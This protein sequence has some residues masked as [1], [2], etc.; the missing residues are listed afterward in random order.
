MNSSWS[1]YT[2][3]SG[4]NIESTPARYSQYGILMNTSNVSVTP[5]I[6]QVIVGYTI[7]NKTLNNNVVLL[8]WVDLDDYFYDTDTNDIV[9]ISV[10]GN[11]NINVEIDQSTR[12]VN[13]RPLNNIIGS[14]N[15]MFTFN[16]SFVSVYS[17]YIKITYIENSSDST[18]PSPLSSGGEGGGGGGVSIQ[19]ETKSSDSGKKFIGFKLLQPGTPVYYENGTVMAVVRVFNGANETL[20]GIHLSAS[21]SLPGIIPLLSKEYIETLD[22]GEEDKFWVM[23]DT[24]TVSSAFDITING[25][26]DNPVLSDSATIYMSTLQKGQVNKTQ[27]NTKIDFVRD[28]LNQ[29]PECL[30]LNEVLQRASDYVKTGDYAKASQSIDSVI[31]SCKYLIARA[32]KPAQQKTTIDIWKKE[33]SDL[34]KS[35][36][37]YLT[38]IS[39]IVSSLLIFGYYLWKK[40]KSPLQLDK[41][42]KT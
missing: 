12:K 22:T 34:M 6:S 7:A 13:L 33:I 30:E 36:T 3:T 41:D 4:S 37:V 29:N 9:N 26:V 11:T 16:D 14:E 25:T 10:S 20:S 15:I 24:N 32:E 1:N 27:I 39:L 5:N 17:N 38:L 42:T 28:L 18:S 31:E 23:V 40:P 35:P 21:T 2:S 8:N 19:T